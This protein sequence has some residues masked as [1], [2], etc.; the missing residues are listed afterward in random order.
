MRQVVLASGNAGKL[1]EFGQCLAPLGIDGRFAG[2]TAS[3]HGAF[4]IWK[5]GGG[6]LA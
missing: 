6:G 4:R 2:G 3:V 1:I 5:N